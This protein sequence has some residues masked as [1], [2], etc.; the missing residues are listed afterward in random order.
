MSDL[1]SAGLPVDRTVEIGLL[2]LNVTEAHLKEICQCF[3]VVEEVRFGSGAPVRGHPCQ[4]AYVS[5]ECISGSKETRR[6]LNRGFIDG[7]E[8]VV[9]D[10]S[11]LD[12]IQ[13]RRS[14]SESSRKGRRRRLRSSSDE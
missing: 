11:P 8:V 1:S 13:D 9:A 14:G 12:E 5:F 2:T 6:R 3:G 4:K 10:L 7:Q